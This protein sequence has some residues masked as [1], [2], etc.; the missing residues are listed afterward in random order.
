MLDVGPD[1]RAPKVGAWRMRS[2]CCSCAEKTSPGTKWSAPVSISCAPR[3]QDPGGAPDDVY[4]RL[5]D[6]AT[7]LPAADNGVDLFNQ[8]LGENNVCTFDVHEP[9]PINM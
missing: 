7:A 3:P 5:A 2:R 9:L 8:P 1:D 6:E 4:D